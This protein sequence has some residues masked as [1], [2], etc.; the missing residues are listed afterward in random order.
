MSNA[1]PTLDFAT[2]RMTL[3]YDGRSYFG[4]QRHRENPTIQGA[5]EGAIEAV[6]GVRSAVQGSGRT[7]RGAH[8][9]GQVATV[10]LPP[11]VEAKYALDALNDQLP[12]DIRILQFAMAPSGFH[13][14]DDATSKTYR[15][16]IW[17]APKCPEAQ[18]GRVWHI[19]GP[20]DIDAMR[21]A[22]PAFLGELDFASFAKK[23]NFK[24]AT[25]VRHLQH[26]ELRAEAPLIEIIMRADGFLYKI[27]RNIVRAII[28]VG[29]GRTSLAQLNQIIAAKDRRTAPGTA[30]ASGLYLETVVY[31][32][33]AITVPRPLP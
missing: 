27:V 33:A 5:L 6:F 31:D 18:V 2:Y 7:D 30:P 8:A 26:I 1:T 21:A 20:L 9:S 10:A 17:N 14:R 29:E 3:S 23:P 25:T 4:W 22:C 12:D 32:E 24:Q 19:P 15:Y 28:K 11:G 16:V 13:A